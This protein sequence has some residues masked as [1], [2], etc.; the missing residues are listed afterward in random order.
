MTAPVWLVE[1]RDAVDVALAAVTANEKAANVAQVVDVLEKGVGAGVVDSEFGELVN[2]SVT[3]LH[4]R[5]LSP[6]AVPNASDIDSALTRVVQGDISASVLRSLSE[7]LPRYAEQL[8]I[9]V[10]QGWRTHVATTVGGVDDLRAL[11]TVLKAIPGQHDASL[12]LTAAQESV[13]RLTDRL[14]GSD[15]AERLAAATAAV[16]QAFGEA[17][18]DAEVRDFL[19]AC[20]RSGALMSQLTPGV[21]SWIEKNKASDR[22]VVQL[23]TAT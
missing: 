19:V 21:R 11:A 14:P 17:V 5:W 15:S 20:S 9:A 13:A 10:A 4:D 22:F 12:K 1:A 16:N 23:G 18:E 3:G 6:T 2:A 7:H 8:R